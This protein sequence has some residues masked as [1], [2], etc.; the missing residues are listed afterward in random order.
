MGHI[1]AAM[2]HA[3][4][5]CH[6]LH[7]P[8]HGH[9]DSYTPAFVMDITRTPASKRSLQQWKA[10]VRYQRKTLAAYARGLRSPLLRECSLCNR[11]RQP[12]GTEPSSEPHPETNCCSYDTS[13][14]A[15]SSQSLGVQ[16]AATIT[17]SA[18]HSFREY[19]RQSQMGSRVPPGRTFR[20]FT[21][22]R[23]LEQS[24]LTNTPGIEAVTTDELT[25]TPSVWPAVES[26]FQTYLQ[27]W[28]PATIVRNPGSHLCTPMGISV[29]TLIS[30]HIAE[31]PQGLVM[32]TL[33][34]PFSYTRARVQLEAMMGFYTQV[35]LLAMLS[36]CLRAVGPA[37]HTV[38]TDALSTTRSREEPHLP[39]HELLHADALRIAMADVQGTNIALHLRLGATP[40]TEV[41]PYWITSIR[42][43]SAMTCCHWCDFVNVTEAQSYWFPCSYQEDAVYCSR[44][45]RDHY[46][47]VEQLLVPTDR[48][49][50]QVMCSVFR[51]LARHSVWTKHQLIAHGLRRMIKLHSDEAVRNTDIPFHHWW[52][53]HPLKA[54]WARLKTVV[55]MRNIYYRRLTDTEISLNLA[56]LQDEKCIYP[57][58]DCWTRYT[59]RHN[60][61]RHTWDN[62]RAALMVVITTDAPPEDPFAS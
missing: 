25:G 55:Q 24:Q 1:K 34:S 17:S 31:N 10:L 3:V 21:S 42:C 36:T 30:R 39:R 29:M 38:S 14:A 37:G 51:E 44:Q 20:Q 15:G 59:C 54:E 61:C 5:H 28:I 19:C 57:T 43:T 49:G 45:C 16:A 2:S 4:T 26:S 50:L 13:N 46:T 8:T 23:E 18:E 6:R 62:G 40:P 22:L 58:D 53:A 9:V 7:T 32:G 41:N 56:A 27:S 52:V 12:A 11:N 33:S 48:G 35:Y 47:S 60:Q